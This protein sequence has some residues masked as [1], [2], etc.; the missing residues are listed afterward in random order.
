MKPMKLVAFATAVIFAGFGMATHAQGSRADAEK[1]PV[2]KAMLEELGRSKA[3]LQ[4]PGFEKPFFIEYRVQ[5][6]N[7]FETR[8]AFGAPQASAHTHTRVARVT[9]RVGDYK[10]DSSVLRGDGAMQMNGLAELITITRYWTQWRDGRLI[11]AVLHNNDLNQVTWEMHA[12]KARRSSPNP[13][14]CPMSTTPLSR[15]GSASAASTSTKHRRSRTRGTGRWRLTGR[16][17]WTCAATRTCRRSHR[18]RRLTRRKRWRP[19]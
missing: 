2:L 6:I 18:T 3:Q 14:R 16:R 19:R 11:V 7:A 12:W 1:D 9:V 4:L 10:T 5:E 17:Y 8:A 15:A 13:R